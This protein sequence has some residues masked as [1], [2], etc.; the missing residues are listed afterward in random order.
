[1]KGFE[2]SPDSYWG[3][4]S[5]T[6]KEQSRFFMETSESWGIY[7][8]FCDAHFAQ[9]FCKNTALWFLE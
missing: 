4:K 9:A 5:N 3:S 6:I 8:A 7:Q 2:V 1:M